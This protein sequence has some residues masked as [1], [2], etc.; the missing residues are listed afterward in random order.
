MRL[1]SGVHGVRCLFG[2]I[3]VVVVF[4]ITIIITIV[5]PCIVGLI[6]SRAPLQARSY[7]PPPLQV[8]ATAA[9]ADPSTDLR[10]LL[11]LQL[12]LRQQPGPDRSHATALRRDC[13]TDM[14]TRANVG[15]AYLYIHVFEYICT[16]V[17]FLGMYLCMYM[18]MHMPTRMRVHDY[19]YINMCVDICMVMCI[20][21]SV[22]MSIHTDSVVDNS[23]SWRGASSTAPSVVPAVCR[24]DW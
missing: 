8:C 22:H 16:H 11:M 1:C 12:Q 15:T 9:S 5:T 14:F 10:V 2:P 3:K 6:G 20:H 18:A 24:K 7:P 13:N 19:A 21:N 17:I 4:F 23:L